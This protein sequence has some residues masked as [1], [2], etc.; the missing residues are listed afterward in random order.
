MNGKAAKAHRKTAAAG[1]LTAVN[2]V[3]P[4]IEA[5]LSNEQL[6]RERVDALER[7]LGS[8]TEA[9]LVHGKTM[10]VRVEDLEH[11]TMGKENFVRFVLMEGFIQRNV[12]G[13]L[14]WLLTGK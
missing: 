14:R 11:W 2:T 4:V 1:A 6:T 9:A 8:A 10:H 13:R 12:W 7:A 5:A 3:R